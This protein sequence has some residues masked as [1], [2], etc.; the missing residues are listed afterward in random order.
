M[1]IVSNFNGDAEWGV[2][3]YIHK[4]LLKFN[5]SSCTE[6]LMNGVEW[7]YNDEIKKLYKDYKR[8]SLL[9][10]WSPCEFTGKK[11]YYHFEHY[12]FFDDVF[13]CVPVYMR[14]HE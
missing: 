2:V 13:L 6:V 5:G 8:K 1:K 11:D 10:L 3:P 14:V 9:A 12:D 4:S 7:I